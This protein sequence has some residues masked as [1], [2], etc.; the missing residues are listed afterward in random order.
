[1]KDRNLQIESRLERS[2]RRQVSAPKLDGRFDAAVWS[3]IAAE[4]QKA[5]VPVVERGPMPRWL[6][7][8]NFLGIAV[9]VVLVAVFATRAMSGVDVAVDMNVSLP[10]FSA[11]QQALLI[12]KMGPILSTVAVLFGFMFTRFGRRLISALR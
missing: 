12:K 2:M 6:M 3:R 1:M 10:S 4:E 5:R 7:A 11:E 8:C 9:T